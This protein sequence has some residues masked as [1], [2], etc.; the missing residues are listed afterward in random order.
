[1]TMGVVMLEAFLGGGKGDQCLSCSCAV[2]W[3]CVSDARRSKYRVKRFT[4]VQSYPS[5]LTVS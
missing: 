3:F 1:M 4:P 5:T 2:S